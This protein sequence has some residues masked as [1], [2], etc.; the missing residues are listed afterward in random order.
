MREYV[1]AVLA[2]H[3]VKALEEAKTKSAAANVPPSNKDPIKSP[4]S[5][6]SDQGDLTDRLQKLADLRTKGLLTDEEF[7][8]AKVKVLQSHEH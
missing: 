8:A 2:N 5:D 1:R 4:P 7:K 3:L 6:D